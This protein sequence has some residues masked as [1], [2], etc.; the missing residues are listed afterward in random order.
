M[1]DPLLDTLLDPLLDTLST[2]FWS[3]ISG[4]IRLL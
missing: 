1:M 3:H 2:G 4:Y